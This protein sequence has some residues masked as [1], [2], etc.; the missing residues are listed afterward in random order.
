MSKDEYDDYT[1]SEERMLIWGK[2]YPELSKQYTETVCTGAILMDRP[3]LL[4]IYPLDYRYLDEDQ[5]P[6]KWDVITA[7]IKNTPKD[8]RPE[9][10][11]IDADS[12]SVEGHIGTDDDWEVRRKYM[13][14]DEHMVSGLEEMEA[15]QEEDGTSLGVLKPEPDTLDVELEALSDDELEAHRKKYK[16]I[17]AQRQLWPAGDRPVP[18]P[19]YKPR[20]YFKGPEDSEV[21][22]RRCLDWEVIEGA[23]H[24]FGDPDPSAGFRKLMFNKAF[25]DDH[26]PYLVL[27]N[28]HQFQHTFVVVSVF[29]PT[30]KQQPALF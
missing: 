29:Y 11:R 26:E 6:S 4:R 16:E 23:K 5:Q 17:T 25:S 30:R 1:W 22:D 9:S 12:I 10:R 3:G 7:R 13:L 19:E 15:R 20:I 21:Y 28:I 27:G 14:R 8:S 24:H 18:A 2:T